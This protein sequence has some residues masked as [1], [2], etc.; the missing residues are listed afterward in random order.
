MSRT[1]WLL[2]LVMR[3]GYATGS[4]GSMKSTDPRALGRHKFAS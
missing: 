3:E 2:E 1:G 4:N